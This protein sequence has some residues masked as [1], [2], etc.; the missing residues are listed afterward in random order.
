MNSMPDTTF[1]RLPYKRSQLSRWLAS[2][3]LL[4]ALGLALGWSLL[5]RPL[6]QHTPNPQPH[7][8]VSLVT[9]T[10]APV[11]QTPRRQSSPKPTTQNTTTHKPQHSPR[12]APAPR[13]IITHTKATPG[14]KKTAAASPAETANDLR[15]QQFNQILHQAIDQQKHYPLAALRMRQQGTA[16]VRF[17]LLEDGRVEDVTLLQTSGFQSLDHSALHAVQSIAPF[18]PARQYLSNDEQF[19][20]DIVFRI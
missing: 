1:D 13:K 2:S 10:A 4:H 20:V 17:R 5:A 7:M 3:L 19:Y 9:P 8:Q 18:A 11:I 15:K 16:R 14:P 12:V 6:A